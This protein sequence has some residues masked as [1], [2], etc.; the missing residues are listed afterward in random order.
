MTKSILLS[1]Q[2]GMAAILCLSFLSSY[3]VQFTFSEAINVAG[4][5]RTLTQRI[6]KSYLQ[7]GLGASVNQSRKQL[8]DAVDLFESQHAQ[9]K[10]FSRSDV[11]TD[12]L[13]AIEQ[14]WSEFKSAALA[15]PEKKTAMR[16]AALDEQLLEMCESVVYLIEDVA[17]GG[18]ARLVNTAGR[19]R[20]LSQRMAKFYMLAASGLATPSMMAKLDRAGNE[21]LGALKTLTTAPEN[22][23]G[24]SE[25]LDEVQE[26]WVWMDS[27][28]SFQQDAYYPLIVNNASEKIL[29]LMDSITEMYARLDFSQ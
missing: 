23:I 27:S 11:V 17:G 25:K 26:Q 4:R 10:A 29:N 8:K 6:T 1:I 14:T 7:I 15:E 12:A 3:A 5:Q 16:L 22:S 24:I 20:M 13:S 28:L 18:Y 21:F 9:L 19:Q 2:S